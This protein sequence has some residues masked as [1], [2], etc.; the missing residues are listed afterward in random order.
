MVDDVAP[1]PFVR[2]RVEGLEG[3]DLIQ[4]RLA[5]LP[6]VLDGAGEEFDADPTLSE[7]E[8]LAGVAPPPLAAEAL[9]RGLDR[10][11]HWVGKSSI[12]WNAYTQKAQDMAKPNVAGEVRSTP[13]GADNIVYGSCFWD[14]AEDEALLL[15]C[16]PPVAQ[17][18]NFTIH[19]LT[20]LESPRLR[21]I[22]MPWAGLFNG[23]PFT[24]VTRSPGR[25]P[26]AMNC[27]RLR[28]G[29]TR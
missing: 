28:P 6:V 16:E 22:S 11:A 10:V 26:R 29:N 23:T 24:A 17:Y 5:T 13:G 27:W 15:T 1:G 14:L 20:W 21:K 2:R 19:T 9:S 18:W 12:Y 8:D 25:R 7:R 3:L 4:A